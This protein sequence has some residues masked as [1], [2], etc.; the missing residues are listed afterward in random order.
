M[1]VVDGRARKSYG[2]V[3]MS[4]S[5]RM[6]GATVRP[7]QQEIDS[8]VL[9]VLPAQGG[10][11]EDEYLWLSDHSSQLIELTD[12][13][14]EL[15]P[16]PTDEHQSILA[17]LYELFAAF[18]HGRGGKVLFAPLRLRIADGTFREPDLLLVRD[19]ADARRGNRFW[20][21]ADVVVEVVSPDQPERDV[22]D[23]RRDYAGA[24]IPEYWIVDPRTAEV[25]VLTYRD[26]AYIEHGTFARGAQVESPLLPGLTVAV[27]S[28]FNAANV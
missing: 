24:G 6:S 22:V 21:G 16:M 15:L 2:S 26:G 27:H 12:G 20:T 1:L 11:R 14:L 18:V 19:A 25:T 7:V 3:A 28:L 10:W 13:H 5:R 9:D 17:F 4:A 23:K 8:F